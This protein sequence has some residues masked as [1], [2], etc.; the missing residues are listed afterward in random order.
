MKIS[1]IQLSV[2]KQI[3]QNSVDLP[4]IALNCSK[5]HEIGFH[6]IAQNWP[7]LPEI[8]QIATDSYHPKSMKLN[9]FNFYINFFNF[10]EHSFSRHWTC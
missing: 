3:A 4:E 10:S 5:L 1:C 2:T 6:Q 8:T 7:K 9:L